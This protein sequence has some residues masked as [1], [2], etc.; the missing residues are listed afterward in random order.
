MDR[1]EIFAEKWNSRLAKQPDQSRYIPLPAKWLADQSY[2]DAN[3][4]PPPLPDVSRVTEEDWIHQ[5]NCHHG[6]DGCWLNPHRYGPPPGKRRCLVP[7]HLFA[8]AEAERKAEA[9]RRAADKAERE[10]LD[11]E[12]AAAQAKEAEQRAAQRAAERVAAKAAREAS[13]KG[14]GH[15]RQRS[16]ER[17]GVPDGKRLAARDRETGKESFPIPEEG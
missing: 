4:K 8:V 10:R 5:I 7:P 13:Y 9:Q 15:E 16:A 12:Y 1:T 11:I 2:L 6:H 17:G 3:L 14:A